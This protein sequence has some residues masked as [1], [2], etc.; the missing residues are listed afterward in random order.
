MTA[1]D[2]P[3]AVGAAS[4]VARKAGFAMSCDADTGRFLAVLAAGVPAGGRVLELGTGAGVGTAWLFHGL[5]GRH[6][7]ALL[8]VEMDPAVAELADTTVW[9]SWAQLLVDDAVAVLYRLAQR[10]GGQVDLIFADAQGGKWDELE[11][12]ISALRP[13]GTLVVDDMTPAAFVDDLHAR[14]TREVREALLRHRELVAAEIAWSTGLIV[15]TKKRN[16]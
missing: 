12:T 1:N 2:L 6:D 10:P 4:K 8:S 13:G 7:V 5:A 3:E 9:P 15:A 11:A 16:R 14:R